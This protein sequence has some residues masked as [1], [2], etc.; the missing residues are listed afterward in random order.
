MR[1]G[2]AIWLQADATLDLFRALGAEEA[3]R[4]CHTVLKELEGWLTDRELERVAHAHAALGG[5]RARLLARSYLIE[6]LKQECYLDPRQPVEKR[7]IVALLD[8]FFADGTT[9]SQDL[10]PALPPA[11]HADRAR[12]GT[13]PSEA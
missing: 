11:E 5:L 3:K 9:S 10:A 8:T 13:E 7:A 4:V 6:Y 12:A 1:R 2:M